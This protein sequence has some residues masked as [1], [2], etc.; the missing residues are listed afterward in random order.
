MTGMDCFW[1]PSARMEKWS[2]LNCCRLRLHGIIP[3][4]LLNII[5]V[6]FLLSFSTSYPSF[7]DTVPCDTRTWECGICCHRRLWDVHQD[8]HRRTSL[9]F[10]AC[11]GKPKT[12]NNHRK[13]RG[14]VLWLWGRSLW[15]GDPA[16][17]GHVHLEE[18]VDL[19][20]SLLINDVA[21]SFL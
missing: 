11:G 21:M 7:S 14:E 13:L 18:N 9:S 3:F 19:A 5:S 10:P 1:V 16:S 15:L 6:S 2:G 12:G 4:M 17:P 20:L 8:R